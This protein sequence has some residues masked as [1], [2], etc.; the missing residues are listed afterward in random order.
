MPERFRN[1]AFIL[2]PESSPADWESKLS[3]L[4]IPCVLSPPHDKDVDENGQ[5]KKLHFHVIL[6]FDS[7]KT[8]PQVLNYLWTSGFSHVEFVEPIK[9]LKSYERYLIHM[10]DPDKFQ[11]KKED[12]KCFSGAS[13]LDDEENSFL[14]VNEIL[15]YIN[16]YELKN[17]RSMSSRD[18]IDIARQN[19]QWM[20][21]LCNYSML[22][23]VEIYLK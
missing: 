6:K 5:V 18:F 19:N 9:S 21:V 20:R 13:Y 12:V 11:Y 7:V 23:L 8:I 22:R 2:Y 3:A 14:I 1:F 16:T 10:D 17:R 15:D 4:H